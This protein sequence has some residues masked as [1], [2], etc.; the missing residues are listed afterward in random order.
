MSRLAA[1]FALALLSSAPALAAEFTCPDASTIAQVGTCPTE[2]DLRY[3]FVGYC[4]DN[5]RMYDKDGKQL[6]VSYEEYHAAKNISL[7]ESGEFQGYLSC[8]TPAETL[9]A[10]KFEGV[11][12][13]KVGAMTKVV[14][15]YDSGVEMIMRTRAKC[16]AEGGKIT[17]QD[18]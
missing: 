5:A 17:C 6:C 4:S 18:K 7:W 14:C 3:S 12:V 8:T 1:A 16:T 13:G 15:S 2:A 11:A 9:K 10:A